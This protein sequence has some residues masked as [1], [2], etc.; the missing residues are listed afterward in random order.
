M[1]L[2]ERMIQE[3]IRNHELQER[4]QGELFEYDYDLPLRP[5]LGAF[6]MPPALPEEPHCSCEM[7]DRC[8]N[9]IGIKN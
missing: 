4:D 7:K 6:L 9:V 5:L 8:F 3:Y 2:N 1:T